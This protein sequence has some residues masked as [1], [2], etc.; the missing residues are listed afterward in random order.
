V[1]L[2]FGSPTDQ[3]ELTRL[4]ELDS[5][6][7]P[8]QPVLLAK[9]DGQLQAGL[10]LAGGAVP[11]PF[12]PTADLIDLVRA[13]VRQLD[14]TPRSGV[15]GGC[16]SGLDSTL[17]HGAEQTANRDLACATRRGRVLPSASRG[18]SSPSGVR[19]AARVRRLQLDRALAAREDPSIPPLLAARADQLIYPGTRRRIAACLEQFALTADTPHG[20]VR[21]LPS[22][23]AM[24]PNQQPLFELAR[25]LCNVGLYS[26]H[27]IA[28]LELVLCDGTRPA[29]TG[30][31]GRDLVAGRATQG[32]CWWP[33]G[34][35]L[36]SKPEYSRTREL[37]R[38]TLLS[39]EDRDPRRLRWSSGGRWA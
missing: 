3:G 37:L 25:R 17:W 35:G 2:R 5:A 4:A 32:H 38:P 20:G 13:R 26:A 31:S 33:G 39:M 1:T 12:Y 36:R 27:R 28:M 14:A 30:P 16:A 29:Y 24:R 11:D 21:T 9:A 23:A 22:R 8:T 15:P 19:L 34:A 6:V 10:V 7:P 18:C